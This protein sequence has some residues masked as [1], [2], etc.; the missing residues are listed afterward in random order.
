MFGAARSPQRRDPEC[1][2]GRGR[3]ANHEVEAGRF[4]GGGARH[5][6]IEELAIPERKDE[7]RAFRS[8][9]PVRAFTGLMF[10]GVT[11]RKGVE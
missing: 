10:A 3:D 6:F 4:C 11:P 9:M 7:I 1:G 5:L 8:W 2:K